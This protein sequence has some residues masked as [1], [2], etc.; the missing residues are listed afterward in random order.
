[1]IEYPSIKHCRDAPVGKACYAFKK[2]DGSNLRWQWTSKKGWCK[3]GTRGSLFD[4]STKP[5]CQA[6]PIFESGIGDEIVKAMTKRFVGCRDFTVFTEFF[7]PSSFAG[8]HVEAEPKELVLF[9]VYL[10]PIGF[11]P[12]KIFA[13]LFREPWAAEVVYTGKMNHDFI[14]AVQK[15]EYGDGEGVVCKGKDWSAKIKTK[16]WINKLKHHY[17]QSWEKHA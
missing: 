6:I 9:D 1:M 8:N 7:G 4:E 15:G 3:R 14:N 13:D 10:D 17:G 16:S 2:Y 12:P 5:W 11:V